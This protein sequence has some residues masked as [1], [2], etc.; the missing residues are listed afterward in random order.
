LLCL[1]Y[2][3]GG[4][5]SYDSWQ[6]L[7]PQ[8]VDA[9]TLRLPGRENRIDEP[10]PLDLRALAKE[11]AAEVGPYLR[12]RFAIFGHSMGALLA[13]E[14]THAL[15]TS[16]GIEPACLFVSGMRAPDRIGRMARYGNLDEDD[17]RSAVG[18]MGGT[19]REVLANAELWELF[20]PIIRSDLAMCD[21]YTHV[22]TE[23]LGC[24]LVA[25]GSKQDTDLDDES[26]HHWGAHTT[27]PFQTRMF[28]GSHFYFQ[29][30]P[31]ALAMDLINRLHQYVLEPDR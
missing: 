20:V 18:T 21:N 7:L 22:P 19:D 10:L 29:R 3:G 25:Y 28:P 5:R 27:G 2:A 30:W 13:Y 6:Q 31:E 14:L 26:L 17:L 11:V 15:R 12:G 9:Q 24:P 23:P 4:A 8:T 16:F 1:T